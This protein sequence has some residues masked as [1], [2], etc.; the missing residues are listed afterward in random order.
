M[1]CTNITNQKFEFHLLNVGLVLHVDD[2]RNVNDGRP[3]TT[4][5]GRRTIT[6]DHT[7][8]RNI[9]RKPPT[10]NFRDYQTGKWNYEINTLY[11]HLHICWGCLQTGVRIHGEAA[12]NVHAQVLEGQVFGQQASTWVN[13]RER[14]NVQPDVAVHGS[15]PIGRPGVVF[16]DFFRIPLNRFILHCR[17][18]PK[19]RNVIMY[20]IYFG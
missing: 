8:R 18:G 4:N 13:G 6:T 9:R 3:T 1:I 19:L 7:G 15:Q 17:L 2:E 12:E 5:D 14:S 10:T 11:R 20:A 16:N